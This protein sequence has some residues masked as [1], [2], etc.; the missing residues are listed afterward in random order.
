MGSL[1]LLVQKW[2]F[3]GYKNDLSAEG[4]E[5]WKSLEAMIRPM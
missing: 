5:L 4:R 1:R 3:S 2:K